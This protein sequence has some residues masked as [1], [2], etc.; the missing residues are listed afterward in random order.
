[1]SG[2]RMVMLCGA[3]TGGVCGVGRAVGGWGMPRT[4][5]G[6]RVL[7]CQRG[8][9]FAPDAWS[10]GRGGG[11]L[12]NGGFRGQLGHS[13]RFHEGLSCRNWTF[14]SYNLYSRF[15]RQK[16]TLIANLKHD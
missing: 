10:P 15:P 14:P 3:D 6:K 12:P 5:K 9:V 1:M 13:P 7:V 11:A 8:G 4:G 16:W 2:K